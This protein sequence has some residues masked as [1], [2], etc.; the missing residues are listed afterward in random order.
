MRKVIGKRLNLA[1]TLVLFVFGIMMA[2]FIIVG[3][4][5][6]LLQ[7]FGVISLPGKAAHETGD[8]TFLFPV[9]ILFGLCI[10][11]GTALTAFFSKKALNPISKVIIATN[12]VARGDFSIQISLKGIS[13]L[14]ELS[15]SFNAMVKELSSIE[16][17]RSDFV[18][19]FS[20]EFKTPIVSI[21]GFARLLKGNN[22]TAAERDEYLD[23][24]ISESERLAELS[25]NVLNL[26]KLENTGL[27]TLKTRFRMD[28]QIR[29]V[30]VLLEP[31]WSLK[32][33]TIS[34]ELADTYYLG[35]V[36][37]TQQI[38]L[39]LMD[40]AI[41]FSDTRGQIN[42][43]LTAWNNGIRFVIQDEG[44]GIDEKTK[45][46]IFERFYQGDTTHTKPG[47]GLGLALVKQIV[48]LCDGTIDVAS[49]PGLGSKFIVWLPNGQEY[50][51]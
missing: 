17:L 19:N 20:H 43:S 48:T 11:L 30:I 24:I 29:K 35:N 23:I 40:N 4:S 44:Y 42:I 37:Y 34:V 39:N 32:E 33:I 25:T 49:Q 14:E 28:E 50:N 12:K 47:N 26:S 51:A 27:I 16:T 2:T 36:D 1:I 22:L 7:H 13:E 15:N 10:S 41:K 38:W 46:H 21:K 31:K 18:N 3:G 9:F 45:P 8:T 6:S 5:A